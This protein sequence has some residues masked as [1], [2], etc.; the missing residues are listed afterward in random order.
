MPNGLDEMNGRPARDE[1]SARDRLVGH[2]IAS[3][4]DGCPPLG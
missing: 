2:V 1:L 3:C 4:V